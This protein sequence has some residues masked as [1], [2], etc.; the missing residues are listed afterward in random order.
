MAEKMVKV[1]AK[2]IGFYGNKRRREG[3]VFEVPEGL[4]SKTTWFEVVSAA[5]PLKHVKM[6]DESLPYG[7]RRSKNKKMTEDEPIGIARPAKGE[8]EE[9]VL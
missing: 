4:L 3:S 9:D 2:E 1:V 6:P 8:S 7:S 5:T